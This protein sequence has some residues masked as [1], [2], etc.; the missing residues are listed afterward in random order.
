M[1]RDIEVL[2]TKK[3]VHVRN[4]QQRS[5]ESCEKYG[6]VGVH[7]RGTSGEQMGHEWH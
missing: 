2:L 6:G 4:N 3:E 7:G 1:T 5:D